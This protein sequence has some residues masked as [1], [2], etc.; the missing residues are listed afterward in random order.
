MLKR[1][2]TL[3]KKLIAELQS[4]L[5]DS[6]HP[7]QIIAQRL[8]A[9]EQWVLRKVEDWLRDGYIRRIGAILYHRQVEFNANAMVIWKAPKTRVKQLGKIMA[10][11]PEVSHCYERATYPNWQY[12]LY[13]MIHGKTK[14]DCQRV[15]QRIAKKTGISDYQLL[16][17]AHEFKKQSMQYF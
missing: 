14:K 2:T 6:L 5:P 9:K 8:G 16:F 13:T 17:S 11:F 7:F 3:E 1:F 10:S 4:D 12:N 15:T